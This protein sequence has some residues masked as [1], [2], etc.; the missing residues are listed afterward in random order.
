MEEHVFKW[1]IRILIVYYLIFLIISFVILYQTK[2]KISYLND[3]S[4]FMFLCH[5]FITGDFD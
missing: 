5:D 3:K 4:Y 1:T 2:L